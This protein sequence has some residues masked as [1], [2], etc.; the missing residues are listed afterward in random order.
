MEAD[1]DVD[2]KRLS[3][4]HWISHRLLAWWSV[5]VVQFPSHLSCSTCF[6][7]LPRVRC[8]CRRW[9]IERDGLRS[10]ECATE[11]F[12]GTQ[13]VDFATAQ[14]RSSVC[15]RVFTSPRRERESDCFQYKC[16]NNSERG[17]FVESTD[18]PFHFKHETLIGCDIVTT[19]CTV[20]K[21]ES[22]EMR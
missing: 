12:G 22:E 15:S 4:F 1:C 16:S 21:G 8:R 13:T 19:S 10:D 2:V 17:F 14:S 20:G 6:G 11:E 9:Q 18:Q 7:I 5:R 3:R